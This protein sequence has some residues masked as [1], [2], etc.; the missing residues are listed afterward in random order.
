M[1]VYINQIKKT[2]SWR[3]VSKILNKIYSIVNVT[4]KHPFI[5]SY[6]YEGMQLSLKVCIYFCD[7]HS[8]YTPS[9]YS[10]LL[11]STMA[12]RNCLS[13]CTVMSKRTSPGVPPPPPPPPAAPPESSFSML[14]RRSRLMV[15]CPD[16]NPAQAKSVFKNYWEIRHNNNDHTKTQCRVPLM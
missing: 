7:P 9:T 6:L 5:Y 15:P 4:K 16:S 11:A 2:M 13:C 12:C 3:V 10:I 1:Y 14:C 8:A